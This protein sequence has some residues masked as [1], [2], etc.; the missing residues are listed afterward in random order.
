[1]QAE[2]IRTG[3]RHD[4][5]GHGGQVLGGWTATGNAVVI[6]GKVYVPVREHDG[7]ELTYVCPAGEHIALSWG[8]G[9]LDHVATAL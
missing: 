6:E 1:M 3:D 2:G 5:Y 7:R 9:S 4:D 8:A